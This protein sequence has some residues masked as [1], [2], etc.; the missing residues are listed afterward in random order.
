MDFVTGLL[1]LPNW[2]DDS[3]NSIPVLVDQ[4]IKVVY[5]KLVKVMIDTPNLAE[6]IINVVI[7]QHEVPESMVIDQS[8]LFISKFWS[9]LYYFLG[10]KIKLSTTFQPKL[11][12]QTEGEN[13]IMEVY[14]RTFVRWEQNNETRFLL[15]A[16]FAYNNTKNASTSHTPFKL[17]YGF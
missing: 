10:M 9:L 5:Y 3:Y 4:L 13:S 12:S 17:N 8:M 16:Q 6:M 2:K 7:S 11:N 1:I 14:P 15:L